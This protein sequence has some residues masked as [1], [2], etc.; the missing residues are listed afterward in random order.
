[1]LRKKRFDSLLKG[2]D[3]QFGIEFKSARD[4]AS[5]FIQTARGDVACSGDAEAPAGGI[6]ISRTVHEAVAGRLKA[7]FDD[8]G[9][10]SLKNIERPVQAFSVKWKPEVW[11]PLPT[12]HVA[13]AA[14]SQ[15]SSTPLPLP[16]P[17]GLKAAR[18]GG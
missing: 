16:D 10:L 7:T 8:L 1:M 14:A 5:R 18:H 9:S 6:L 4:E 13:I 17:T 2:G 11:Q 12:P 3:A 15:S